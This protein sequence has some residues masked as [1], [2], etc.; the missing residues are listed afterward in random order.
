M[1]LLNVAA[2]MAVMA[3]EELGQASRAESLRAEFGLE[4]LPVAE[5]AC[6][7]PAKSSYPRE[8]S[9]IS[10]PRLGGHEQ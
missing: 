2:S 9:W 4:P 8:R 7:K 10:L 1:R 5:S 6:Q 3:F